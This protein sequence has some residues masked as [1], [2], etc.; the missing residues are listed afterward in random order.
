MKSVK[1]NGKEFIEEIIGEEAI[2]DIA[3][4]KLVYD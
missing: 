1:E 2:A 3:R 4:A